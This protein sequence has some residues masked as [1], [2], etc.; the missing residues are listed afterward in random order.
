MPF[1][2]DPAVSKYT[3]HVTWIS[4]CMIVAFT[5][6]RILSSLSHQHRWL[7]KE[8]IDFTID[9]ALFA[10]KTMKKRM[11]TELVMLLWCLRSL[12]SHPP[13]NE[14]PFLGPFH[15]IMCVDIIWNTCSTTL[16]NVRS[17]VNAVVFELWM[18]GYYDNRERREYNKSK[19]CCSWMLVMLLLAVTM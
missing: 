3:Q 17:I 15:L 5:D 19:G 1:K 14:P 6:M 9:N 13:N 2:L 8:E 12:F 16:H 18:S 7:H 4:R 10:I 11:M